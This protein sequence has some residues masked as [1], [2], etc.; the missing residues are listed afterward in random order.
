MVQID[1]NTIDFQVDPMTQHKIMME[2]MDN[3]K[4]AQIIQMNITQQIYEYIRYKIKM[5]ENLNLAI[6]GEC[7]KSMSSNAFDMSK[8]VAGNQRLR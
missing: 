2:S 7:R 4:F 1:A 3:P 6:K 8:L 5:R